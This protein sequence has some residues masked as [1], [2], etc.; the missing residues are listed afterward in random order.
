MK[1]STSARVDFYLLEKQTR[2]C[3]YLSI[4]PGAS[5]RARTILESRKNGRACVD[6]AYSK[7]RKK[8]KRDGVG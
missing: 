3:S 2:V 5:E 8:K 6:A 4:G 7:K 1:G